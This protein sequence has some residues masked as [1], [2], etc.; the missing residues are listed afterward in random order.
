MSDWPSIVIALVYYG[1]FFLI[2]SSGRS[3]LSVRQS[4][5]KL[6]GPEWYLQK[7]ARFRVGDRFQRGERTCLAF[8]KRRKG[9][10]VI[11]YNFADTPPWLEFRFA[12][13]QKF[14][15]RLLPS[16]DGQP[17]DNEIQVG[18][19]RI[20]SRF[21]IHADQPDVAKA[22][23]TNTQVVEAITH[24][25]KVDRLEVYRGSLKAIVLDPQLAGLN[26]RDVDWI[27]DVLARFKSL[28]EG[29]L[30]A[31]RILHTGPSKTICPFC[32]ESL[33]RDQGTIVTCTDC[34]ARHHLECWRENRLCTTWG[35]ESSQ[36]I[37]SDPF[38][39]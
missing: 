34:G 4:L 39:K 19:E 12:L 3:N 36:Y 25:E 20:D 22:F 27:F 33:Q 30:L 24:M 21:I 13:T 2:R 35:C 15:L 28:Y 5:K 14:W 6:E 29:Q 11:E 10:P 18:E 16:K 7:I 26:A 37:L 1:I 38:F 23:L 17:V 31:M 32:R 9:S 8:F